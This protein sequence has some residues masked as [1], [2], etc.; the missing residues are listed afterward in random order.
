MKVAQFVPS[1]PVRTFA[2]S[3][4][5]IGNGRES[6][7]RLLCKGC[8]PCHF[9][10]FHFLRTTRSYSSSRVNSKGLNTECRFL[11]EGI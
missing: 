9:V 5:N 2:I 8:E 4:K 11:K 6:V 1:V 10:N 7:G 3:R